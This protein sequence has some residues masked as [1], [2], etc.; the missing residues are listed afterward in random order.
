MIKRKEWNLSITLFALFLIVSLAWANDGN[1]VINEVMYHPPND[2]EAEEFIELYN[3][4][5]ETAD[6]SGWKFT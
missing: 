6:L 3:S 2:L 4:G 5:N 1:I